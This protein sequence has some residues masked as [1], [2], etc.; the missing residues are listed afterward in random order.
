MHTDPEIRPASPL[1]ATR[2]WPTGGMRQ[3]YS[4]GPH[5]LSSGEAGPS[6]TTRPDAGRMGQGFQPE[7]RMSRPRDE[8]TDRR[9]PEAGAVPSKRD[10]L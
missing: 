4:S 2:R 5:G 8:E 10:A 6:S 9:E 1:G 7:A 3:A